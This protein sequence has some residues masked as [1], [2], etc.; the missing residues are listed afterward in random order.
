MELST[1]QL[2]ALLF[3]ITSIGG[4]I[5]HKV[6]RFPASIGLLFFSVLLSLV[7]IVMDKTSAFS[8]QSVGVLVNKLDFENLLLHGMLAVLLFAG[9]LHVNVTELKAYKL[10][11]ALFATVGVML[12]TG[13]TGVLFYLACQ[14]LGMDLP[15]VYCLIFGALISPTDPVCV[16]ALLGDSPSIKNIKT[17]ITGE[18]LFNDGTG[19]VLFIVLLGLVHAGQPVSSLDWSVLLLIVKDI[20]GGVVVGLALSFALYLAIKSI[21]SYE[22][23]IMMIIALA[24]SS[25]ALSELLHVSAPIAV[26]TA[27]LFIGN[28]VRHLAMSRKS[29][30]H[31]DAFWS[32]LDEI[33]NAILFVIIGL[34]MVVVV[35]KLD[36]VL[37]GLVAIAITLLA[38]YASILVCALGL[39]R[40]R[41]D[42]NFR[43]TPL[44]MTWAGLRG[45][46][47]IALALSLP[48][49]QYK[50]LI[51]T[52]T[53]VVV[54]FSILLQGLS[55]NRVL[56]W[57]D[58]KG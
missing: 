20:L 21:D 27:G 6:F 13:I 2:L 22:I 45:G 58:R 28:R 16:L 26:V 50:P 29:T 37:V 36:Y 55:F 32:L 12:A 10:P 3:S 15:F 48:N 19:V 14:A 18:A 34:E 56:R 41:Y 31:L 1:L 51:L 17:K 53:Y 40:S 24:L 39:I 7:L 49:D 4:Y 57:I 42:F 25:Y 54:L 8:L 23:E 11:I 44:L 43:R 38:R 33:F 52:A 9:A 46:I 47:S 5:N 35:I 30:E